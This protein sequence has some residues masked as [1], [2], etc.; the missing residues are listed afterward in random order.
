MQALLAA[1]V[2][3]RGLSEIEK[4]TQGGR[5]FRGRE[6]FVASLGLA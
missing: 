4:R 1:A 2:S 6:V 3:A 5:Q